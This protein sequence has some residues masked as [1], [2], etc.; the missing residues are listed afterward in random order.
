MS[1][2]LTIVLTITLPLAVTEPVKGAAN[3]EMNSRLA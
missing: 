1:P 3:L 2:L